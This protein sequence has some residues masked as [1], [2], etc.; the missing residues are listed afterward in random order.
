MAGSHSA[1]DRRRGA[2]FTLLEILVA[3]AIVAIALTAVVSETGQHVNNTIHLRDRTLAHWV[4]LNQLTE[5]QVQAGWP[6]T[7]RSN[8]TVELADREWFWIMEISATPDENVRRIDVEVRA[9]P[10]RG[11]PN[12]TI[13][14]YLPRPAQ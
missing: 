8:G 11:N 2:G 6:S 4:A 3:L 10:E 1:T 14:G 5:Q 12:A 9:D 13:I 7:G